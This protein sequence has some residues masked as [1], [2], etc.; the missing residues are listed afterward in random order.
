[1]NWPSEGSVEVLGQPFGECDLRPTPQDDRVDQFR[2][3]APVFPHPTRLWRLS[4][5]AGRLARPVSRLH[6]S[7]HGRA[8]HALT[9]LGCGGMAR[10]RARLLSQGEQQRVLIARSLVCDPALLILDEPCAGLDPAARLSF[11]EGLAGLAR[12]AD[13][14]TMIFVTHH[15]ERKSGTGS[16]TC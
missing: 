5:R 15:I 4:L 14:P 3:A 9:L 1:M 11:L 12:R 8:L 6:G 7:G 10:Q 16:A 13:A 2:P